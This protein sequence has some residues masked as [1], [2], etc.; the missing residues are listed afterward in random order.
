MSLQTC[1][2]FVSTLL[3]WHQENGR[4]GLPWRESE[5]TPFETMVA[6]ILLQRTTASA[7]S[8]G[9]VPFAALYPTPE[10]VV[11]ATSDEL[12]E[13]IAP[14][15]LTKRASYLERCSG[16][17]LERHDGEVP[18]R[19]SD[20][21]D[22][23]GVGD[24]TA[25]SVAVHAFGEDVAAVD[26]NVRRL[27]SRFFDTGPDANAIEDIADVIVPAGRSGDFLHAMLD[28]AAD[29]CTARSPDCDRC[30]LQRHCEFPETTDAEEVAKPTE[31]PT[32]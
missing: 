13:L 21:L 20:L 27:V 14:L 9:Y 5:R 2:A 19:R 3:D 25:R 17:I 16:Q 15:G 29:V 26:T 7:V 8:G 22:L 11:A 32:E 10:C 23:H 31:E 12:T 6:E 30:A 1:R 24:Y 4:H 28:F 18:R